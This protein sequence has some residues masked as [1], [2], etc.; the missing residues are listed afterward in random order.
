MPTTPK[1]GWTYP[2]EWTDNW[3]NT[4]VT[5]IEAVDL[6]VDNIRVGSQNFTGD[7][8]IKKSQP[9]VRLIGTEASAKDYLLRENAGVIEIAEN[10]GTEAS[11]TWTVRAT[12]QSDGEL[13]IAAAG[14]GVVVRDVGDTAFYRI[15]VEVR[16]GQP[17][18][19]AEPE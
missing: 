5:L 9:A 10:T 17:G 16:D 2:A 11:P 8:T 7:V 19:F 1:Y 6:A 12:L 15:G 3:Y 18:V 13:K 4:F 14:K